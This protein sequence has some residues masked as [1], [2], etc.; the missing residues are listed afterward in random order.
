MVDTCCRRKTSCKSQKVKTLCDTRRRRRNNCSCCPLPPLKC[1][2]KI[3][4]NV[5]SFGPTK[6]IKEKT[7]RVP[8]PIT[9]NY[10]VDRQ[11][12][13]GISYKPGDYRNSPCCCCSSLNNTCCKLVNKNPNSATFCECEYNA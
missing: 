3:T 7:I 9:V 12:S 8:T 2:K 1:S 10:G 4:V 5:I 11:V 6:S 13:C